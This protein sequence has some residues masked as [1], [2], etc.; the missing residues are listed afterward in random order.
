MERIPRPE[1][2]NPQFYRENWRSLNGT[3]E[4]EIDKS[5]AGEEL[6]F[7]SREH[8]SREITVPFC[9]ESQ[10]SGVRVSDFMEAVWYKRSFC[11][12][13]EER[14]GDVL[15]HFGAVDYE[16][17]VFVNG[18]L[19]GI[20]KGGYSSFQMDI[21][22]F[23]HPGEN[24]LTVR[25]VDHTRCPLQPTGKQSERA[26]SHGCFYTRTT[27]IWQS[28]WLEFVPRIRIQ[29]F[30]LTP[31]PEA[32]SV[33][34]EVQTTGKGI[35]NAEC[36]Y[37]GKRTGSRS[38]TVAYRQTRFELSLS[39]KHLWEVGHGRLYDLQLSFGEDTVSTYFG[40]RSIGFEGMKF[41]LNSR[42]VFQR[43]VLDQGFY[44]DGIYT[45]PDDKGI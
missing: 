31:N 13:Y 21:T 25:A 35:L 33:I 15:L 17:T 27:G 19:T 40:L 7:V 30:K 44:P 34:I 12:S 16:C 11:I 32:C 42:P 8:F 9:P 20:H 29:S 37:K 28:V 26:N 6:G 10:L 45:A 39:E 36:F 3:W 1:H 18:N 38:V 23:L 43:L 14:K 22:S 24:T 2:P 4:F 41:L 5:N